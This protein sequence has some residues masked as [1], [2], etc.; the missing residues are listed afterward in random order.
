MSSLRHIQQV[1]RLL[2]G[3]PDG[4]HLLG[5]QLQNSFRGERIARKRRKTIKDGQSRLAIQLLI[6]DGLGE[7]ME[8]RFSEFNPVRANA[9]DIARMTGSDFFKCKS[10]FRISRSPES[11]LP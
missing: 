9:F 10:A 4:S 2:F 11:L 3:E 5:L 8:D 7:A 1:G 6:N